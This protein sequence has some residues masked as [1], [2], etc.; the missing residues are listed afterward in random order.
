MK[1]ADVYQA[2]EAWAQLSTLKIPPMTAYRLMKYAKTV[3][4]EGDLIEQ[5]RVKLI[6]EAAG[7]TEG[8]VRLEP[9]TDQ[10]K[11]FVEEFNTFLLGDSDLKAMDM[12]LDS[13]VS[14][15][16]KDGNMLSVQHLANLEP[17][18]EAKEK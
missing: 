13:L 7:V 18:F 16:A 3:G 9:G 14:L 12:S 10:H 8:E 1:L 4:A 15:L 11:Q 2:G 5:Q 17:F 6:R